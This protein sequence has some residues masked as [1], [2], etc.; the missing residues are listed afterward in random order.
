MLCATSTNAEPPIMVLHVAL[1]ERVIHTLAGVYNMMRSV[2]ELMKTFLPTY[3]TTCKSIK[4]SNT[5]DDEQKVR[6]KN[7]Q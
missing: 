2:N 7:G 1:C 6:I 5:V 4:Q 3:I